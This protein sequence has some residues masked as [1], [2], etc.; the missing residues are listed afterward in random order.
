VAQRAGQ[1]AAAGWKAAAARRRSEESIF[2]A[3]VFS[4]MRGLAVH[5]PN[6]FPI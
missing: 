3:P 1:R 6:A 4:R 5:I 2:A